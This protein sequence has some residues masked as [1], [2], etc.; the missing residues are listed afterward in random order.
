MNN[1]IDLTGKVALV[2]GGGGGIG[3]GICRVFDAC[4]ATVVAHDLTDEIAANAVRAIGPQIHTVSGDITVEENVE[5]IVDAVMAA[6]ERIDVLVNNAGV[7]DAGQ[8]ILKVRYPDWRRVVDVNF[9][10]PYLLS[11]AV[12]RKCMV[13][14]G[15]GVI[16]S[17]AS[18]TGLRTLK[19]GETAYSASKAALV[20]LTRK[21]ALEW[22]EFGIRVNAV[23]PGA[24]N[25]GFLKNAALE[26]NELVR[27]EDLLQMIP[28]DRLGEPEDI[29]WAF[30]FL[31]CDL[32][33]YITGEVLKVNGGFGI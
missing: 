24:V 16:L 31:A 28:L 21:L 13:P 10:A 32:A 18:I 33:G 14:N 25:A 26:Y 29:G 17:T 1:A 15:S 27:E 20:S 3:E 4:G 5:A 12:A 9:A 23:A 8:D 22:G 7:P 6:H 30:A 2:T 19:G 11:H